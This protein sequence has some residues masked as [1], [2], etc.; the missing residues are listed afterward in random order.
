[1]ENEINN[2]EELVEKHEAHLT[3]ALKQQNRA[4]ANLQSL[5]AALDL[6]Y[7]Q[8]LSQ[9]SSRDGLSGSNIYG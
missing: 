5:I 8:I 9:S 6:K 4:I 3:N 7:G 2:L 1:M